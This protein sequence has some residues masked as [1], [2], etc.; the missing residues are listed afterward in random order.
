MRA[1]KDDR[2]RAYNDVFP[3]IGKGDINISRLYPGTIKAFHR[4]ALQDDYWF[5]IKGNLRAVLAKP[6]PT[7]VTVSVT[8]TFPFAN[9]LQFSEI[10]PQMHISE[11]Y[12]SEG[13]I[14][15]IPAGVWHGLQVL[16]YEEAIMLYHI[17]NKYNP[18]KPDEERAPWNAFHTWEFSKK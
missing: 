10:K 12:L 5:V 8:T 6:D 16:G 9:N 11:H 2:N 17:T 7:K 1:F 4:H 15:H 3:E 14:L 18:D 13:D